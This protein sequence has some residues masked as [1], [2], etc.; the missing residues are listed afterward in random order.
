MSSHPQWDDLQNTIE[1]A[2]FQLAAFD[3]LSTSEAVFLR[4]IAYDLL[5]ATDRLVGML[6]G[7]G[8]GKTGGKP[9]NGLGSG[10][11]KAGKHGNSRGSGKGTASHHSK[12]KG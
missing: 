10:K 9:G 2:R 6:E 12:G 3:D 1:A 4:E 11:S 5:N 8:L 7:K